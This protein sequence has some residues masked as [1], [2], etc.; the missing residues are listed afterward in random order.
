MPSRQEAL[1]RL[2]GIPHRRPP[3]YKA[4]Q[5]V[6]GLLVT[7]E[8]LHRVAVL[9]EVRPHQL[10]RYP[11]DHRIMTHHRM[12]TTMVSLRAMGNGESLSHRMVSGASIGAAGEDWR[13]LVDIA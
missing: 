5:P 2:L 8:H 3:R 10:T 1:D 13:R 11:H 6:K 12:A 9:A 7:E 4:V